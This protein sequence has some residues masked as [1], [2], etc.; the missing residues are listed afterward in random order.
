MRGGKH[1]IQHIQ[2]AQRRG[3]LH[4][5]PGEVALFSPTAWW[6][7][8]SPGVPGASFF[9]D[10]CLARGPAVTEPGGQEVNW[11][12]RARLC[13]LAVRGAAF[14]NCPSTGFAWRP[15]GLS[16]APGVLRVWS[17]RPQGAP[18][19]ED[20]QE[21]LWGARPSGDQAALLWGARPSGGTGGL[22]C[23]EPG[24]Q[25]EQA[26]LPVGLSPGLAARE[27]TWPRGTAPEKRVLS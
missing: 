27:L 4:A 6:V 18:H 23:G 17:A 24:L 21:G 5:V 25:G 22:S 20:T 8:R 10:K 1:I 3:F 9:L 7:Q 2:G 16:T 15:A 11:T 13:S 26:A 19:W 14:P 12:S